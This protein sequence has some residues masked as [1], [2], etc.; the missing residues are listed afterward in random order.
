MRKE[1]SLKFVGTTT[2]IDD[3]K[4]AEEALRASETDLRQI[5]D[6]IPGLVCTSSAAGEME[7]TN[8]PFLEYFGR[9]LEEMKDWANGDAVHADDLPRTLLAF[10]QSITTGAP[11]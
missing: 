9:T 1:E 10:M 7:L 2:D 3:R 4:R 6:S 5:L 11:L 8:R